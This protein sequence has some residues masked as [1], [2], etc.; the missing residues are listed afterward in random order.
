M[1]GD[2]HNYRGFKGD[3]ES[4]DSANFAESKDAK[5]NSATRILLIIR[6]ICN[7]KDINALSL[8]DFDFNISKRTFQRDIKK[9]KDF[10]IEHFAYI[11]IEAHSQSAVDSHTR[12]DLPTKDLPTKDSHTHADSTTHTGGEFTL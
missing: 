9:V 1:V 5:D 7:G 3:A 10:F 2:S 11:P 8:D 12:K 4:K 6:E